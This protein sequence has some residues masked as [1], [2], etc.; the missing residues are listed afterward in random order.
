MSKL[1][2][3]IEGLDR[4]GKSTLID[5]VLIKLG[6]YQVIHFGR[7]RSL[8]A[9]EQSYDIDGVPASSKALCHYQRES[10]KNSMRLANSGAKIIF[11]RWFLGECVYSPMYRGF[12]GD[13]VFTFERAYGLDENLDLRLILLTENFDI[14]RH[15]VDD[16]L[17]LGSTD[18][19]E[20]EQQLFIDA[21]NKSII[22]DKKIICVTDANTGNF[23][24]KNDILMEALS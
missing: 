17:S 7:P 11:D 22:R 5:G 18:K 4:L 10:F 19:R 16:G 3:A 14:S 15:L 12:S 6:Y 23:R 21:F 9:Y 8:E 24:P 13:Y 2:Y 20:Q 1:V